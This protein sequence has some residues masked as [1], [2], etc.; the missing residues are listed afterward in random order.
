MGQRVFVGA[1]AAATL[2]AALAA[3]VLVSAPFAGTS[4][5]P[6]ADAR[7]VSS[8]TLAAEEA[9]VTPI[10]PGT[11]DWA[12]FVAAETVILAGAVATRA[13]TRRNRAYKR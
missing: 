12:L 3:A 2:P 7:E 13:L 9:P 10:G 1:S 4:V 8:T 11:A 5:S 6:L